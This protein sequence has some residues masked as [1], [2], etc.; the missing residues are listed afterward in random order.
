MAPKN[1]SRANNF[2][3]S[4]TALRTSVRYISMS[5]S[6]SFFLEIKWTRPNMSSLE[7]RIF[8]VVVY[9][10]ALFLK[11]N[12][13]T[14]LA[15]IGWL[16]PAILALSEIYS[17]WHSSKTPYVAELSLSVAKNQI[18]RQNLG[19]NSQGMIRCY[20]R[21]RPFD[22]TQQ[23]VFPG[24]RGKNHLCPVIPGHNGTE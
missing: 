14:P 18:N 22:G 7:I 12:E 19:G 8:P 21:S 5:P 13:I 23:N 15:A 20:L 16:Y 17:F 9:Y 2:I 4:W 3:S 1:I 24:S 6:N 10:M 11:K